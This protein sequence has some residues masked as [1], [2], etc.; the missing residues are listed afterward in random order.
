MIKLESEEYKAKMDKYERRKKELEIEE[1]EME[2]ENRI[3][4]EKWKNLG[5][6]LIKIGERRKSEE[7]EDKRIREL[8]LNE[9]K[10]LV[11]QIPNHP[12]YNK[13]KAILA[14]TIIDFQYL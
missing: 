3:E 9:L 1:E 14:K 7:N 8:I 2:K 13:Y 12:F 10:Q 5:N 6:D 11:E 4:Q